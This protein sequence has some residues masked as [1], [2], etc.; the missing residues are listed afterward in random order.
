MYSF[1]HQNFVEY[2]NMPD[3]V[4]ISLICGAQSTLILTNN[5]LLNPTMK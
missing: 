4:L 1:I 5:F 2:F 3:T